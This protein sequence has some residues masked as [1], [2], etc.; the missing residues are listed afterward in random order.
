L[1]FFVEG[2][3]LHASRTRAGFVCSVGGY[4]LRVFRKTVMLA[5]SGG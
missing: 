4:A 1:G 5:I 3:A 2:F